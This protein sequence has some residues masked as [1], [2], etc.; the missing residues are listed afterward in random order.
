MR[1]VPPA[2]V[3][4]TLSLICAYIPASGLEDSPTAHA[5][6]EAREDRAQPKAA[7]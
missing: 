5:A 2:V 1:L 6:P 4:S 7:G 3:I